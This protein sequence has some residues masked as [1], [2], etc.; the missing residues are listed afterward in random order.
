MT[1]AAEALNGITSGM[2]VDDLRA[3][4]NTVDASVGNAKL[5]LYSGGTGQF[6]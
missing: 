5:L 4:A 2:T 6:N 3:L 1:T